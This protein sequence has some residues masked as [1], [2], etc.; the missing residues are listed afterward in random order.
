MDPILANRYSWLHFYSA[1]FYM[2]VYHIY[3]VC[4]ALMYMQHKHMIYGEFHIYHYL[5]LEQNTKDNAFST[6]LWYEVWNVEQKIVMLGINFCYN[7]F[8]H[9]VVQHQYYTEHDTVGLY[10][11]F[12]ELFIVFAL[13]KHTIFCGALLWDGVEIP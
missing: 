10:I 12:N 4:L 9:L 6:P 3:R 8:S 13:I 5:F 1:L 11:F 7:K 2:M